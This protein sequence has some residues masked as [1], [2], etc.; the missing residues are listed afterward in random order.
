MADFRG[1][2]TQVLPHKSRHS[3]TKLALCLQP[4]AASIQWFPWN[5]CVFFPKGHKKQDSAVDNQHLVANKGRDHAVL[6]DITKGRFSTRLPRSEAKQCEDFTSDLYFSSLW[7][8]MERA[9]NILPLLSSWPC[10]KRCPS[11]LMEKKKEKRPPWYKWA[12]VQ[13]FCATFASSII[14]F[15]VFWNAKQARGPFE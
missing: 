7:M 10:L 1:S 4:P 6:S 13:P 8:W 15:V 12:K 3:S 11:I 9:E 14:F 2:P 5:F